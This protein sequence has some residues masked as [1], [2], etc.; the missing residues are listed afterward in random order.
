MNRLQAF[1]LVALFWAAVYLPG[2]GDRALKGEEAR[3]VLPAVTMLETGNWVVPYLNGEP[4]LRK[5]PLVNWSIAFS[6][7]MANE[8][9]EWAARLPSAIAMLA[10][11][12]VVFWTAVRWLSTSAAFAAAIIALSGIGLWEKG[13]MAEID[14]I[15]SALTGIAFAVWVA[16][17]VNRKTGW[18]LWFWPVLCLGLATLAKG[19]LHLALFYAVVVPLLVAAG[20]KRQLWSVAHLASLGVAALVVAAWGVPYFLKTAT[21]N[22]EAIW[23]KQMNNVL[24]N[25]Q[26]GKT[27]VHEFN[28]L[29]NGLPW[30]LFTPLWWSRRVLD[31]LD[32]RRRLLVSVVRWPV[33]LAVMG[34]VLIV[35]MVPRYTLPLY[36]MA[37]LLLALVIP[38]LQT[39]VQKTWEWFCM[40]VIVG[41]ALGA[42]FA[43]WLAR[44]GAINWLGFVPFIAFCAT[45]FFLKRGINA[46]AWQ[47]PASTALAFAAAVAIYA[48]VAIPRFNEVFPSR[49]LVAGEGINN[50]MPP[51]SVLYII[52]PG[53]EPAFFYINRRCVFVN[54]AR[55]L[56]PQSRY[57]LTTRHRNRGVETEIPG[58]WE[59]GVFPGLGK[60]Q[61]LLVKRG[62]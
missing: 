32:E 37:A 24:G 12:A 57:V 15:Y 36:P 53:Y 20:E 17:W 59:M 43:P 2:L 1:L 60:R 47:V 35:G 41:A 3:R 40:G 10:M 42:V 26:S 31:G 29:A 22:P 18:S 16:A 62:E 4:Y 61:L 25:G 52:D 6:L 28:S 45:W 13:R 34:L 23:A 48:A 19:P 44:P 8:R 11:A 46:P 5:P 55:E 39:R 21:L 38:S 56:P 51:E 58:A 33:A 9:S 50:A 49:P 7:W 14:A 30:I 27:L 54:S